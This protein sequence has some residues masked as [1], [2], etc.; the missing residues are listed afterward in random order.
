[1]SN[2]TVPTPT[3]TNYRVEFDRIGRTHDVTP[4]VTKADD[5]DVLAETIY[6]YARPHLRSRDVEVVVDLQAMTG[7]IFC[8]FQVGGHFTIHAEA[9]EQ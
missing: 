8:G 3:P 1:M 7:W 5:A 9:V 2:T 4:L 6:R